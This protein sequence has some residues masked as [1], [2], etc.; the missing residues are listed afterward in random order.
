MSPAEVEIDA[1]FSAW[2]DAFRRGDLAALAG[3]LTD[4]YRLYSPGMPPTR[5]ADLRPRLAAVLEAYDVE[6]SY[7]RE[8]QIISGDLAFEH[9]WD[10]QSLRPHGGGEGRE[11]RQRVFLLLRRGDG[12]WRF[13]RGV[14]VPGGS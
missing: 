7:E 5:F 4:D 13:A 11:G 2:A 9:G 12:V 1:L 10:V 14:V 8:E 6:V 3:L